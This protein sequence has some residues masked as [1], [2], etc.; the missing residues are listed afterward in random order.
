MIGGNYTATALVGLGLGV[1]GGVVL[2]PY[3]SLRDHSGTIGLA[4][5]GTGGAL[6]LGGT[7][8]LLYAV[9]TSSES[10]AIKAARTGAGTLGTGL[11]LVGLGAGFAAG[12]LT[13]L[14]T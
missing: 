10:G 12:Q 1:M 6:A 14:N 9:Q 5:A 11:F 7:G 8:A 4:T 3:Q 13:P 2:N